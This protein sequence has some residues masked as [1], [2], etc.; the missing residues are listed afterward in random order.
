MTGVT[1][2]FMVDHFPVHGIP[3]LYIWN[4]YIEP[5]GMGNALWFFM[6]IE[7]SPQL[8]KEKARQLQVAFFVWC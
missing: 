5:Q 6:Q 3:S 2:A 7:Y 8:A 1:E 4:S